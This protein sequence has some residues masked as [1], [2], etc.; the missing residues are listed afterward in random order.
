M[1]ISVGQDMIQ[2]GLVLSLDASDKNSYPGSG[3]TWFDVSGAGYNSTLTNGPTF[4][5]NNGGVI[6]FDGADD[7]V[8][9]PSNN[10]WN[11][12]VFGTATN[13]TIACWAKPDLYEN[14]DTLISKIDLNVVGGWYSANEGPAIWTDVSGFVAVFSSGVCCN[15]GGSILQI[16]YPTSNTQKWF[17]LCLTGD[18]TTL[19]FYVDGAEVGNT[20]ISNRTYPVTVSNVGPTLGWRQNWKGQMGNALFYTRGLTASEVLQNY[21]AMKSRFGLK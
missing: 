6:V 20:L 11:S 4:S 2:D 10:Y 8:Q 1:G 17:N 15:P 3:T 7:Y 21:N 14:W 16:F 5:T 19:R 12:N 9:I 13:F 18:G